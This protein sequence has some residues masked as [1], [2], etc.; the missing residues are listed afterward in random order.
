VWA[1]RRIRVKFIGV[2]A[3][4][5]FEHAQNV[6]KALLPPTYAVEK[7]IFTNTWTQNSEGKQ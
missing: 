2:W 6:P 7:L 1:C 3:E 5:S 4:L